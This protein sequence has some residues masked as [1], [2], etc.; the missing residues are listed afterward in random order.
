MGG[1]LFLVIPAF[2]AL[3]LAASVGCDGSKDFTA[4]GV[5]FSTCEGE[6]LNNQKVI[7]TDLTTG[8]QD[9]CG[10]DLTV[11]PCC[12]VAQIATCTTDTAWLQMV[13]DCR[14]NS[15]SCTE[16]MAC[17][18]VVGTSPSGCTDPTTWECIVSATDAGAQ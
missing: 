10:F 17:L 18:E 5:D 1:K 16:Y 14:T 7:C 9:L 6:I 3:G 13:L 12:C 2:V 11:E 15:G 4:T 8:V